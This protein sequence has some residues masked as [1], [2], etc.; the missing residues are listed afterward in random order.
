MNYKIERGREEINSTGGISLVGQLFRKTNLFSGVNGL[1]MSGVKAGWISH[2]SILKSM[3][4]LF[5]EGRS[6][7]A[8]IGSHKGDLVFQ[9][10][11]DLDKV[12]S[13]ETLRQRI[14]QGS[15]TITDEVLEDNVRLLRL[16]DDF[17]EEKTP[18]ARYTPVAMDVTPLD[19]SGSNK[20]EVGQTYKGC[21]GYAPMMAYVGTNGYLLNCEL[22][23]G[24][25][26]SQ[27]G[28]DQFLPQTIGMVESLG[29]ENAAYVLD[30]AH[31][32]SENIDIFNEHECVYLIK[33]N[34][35]QEMLEWW[36]AMA[37]RVGER[38]SPRTG[39]TVFTGSLSHVKPANCKSDKPV[40]IVFEVIERTVDKEGQ[41]LLFP[42]VEVN[43][44]WTNLPDDPDAVIQLYHN[45]GTSEQF[46]SEFKTDMDVE[47]LASG[48]FKTNF[49]LIRLAMV[50][51]NILRIIGQTALTFIDE[52]PVKIKVTRRRLRSVIQ[53]LIY[54]A[55]KRVEH[56]NRRILKFGRN[57]PWFDVFRRLHV[58][59]C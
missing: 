5:C 12:P 47:R 17:G 27:K 14:D 36:L 43:T 57:C 31:D 6:D 22:R 20:E 25:Q 58:K 26:H 39:K 13:E 2:G 18:H 46:H 34:L 19:N 29:I 35:R 33:R 37:R 52:I 10:S 45:H 3:V 8:D 7:Y 23:P 56:A 53:D 28:M 51:F 59:F 15:L 11:L 30:S 49:L 55:C 21:D 40:F 50:A 38:R 24:V 41:E 54:V 48:K 4:G 32:A 1:I 9:E 42:D 44:W 16:V